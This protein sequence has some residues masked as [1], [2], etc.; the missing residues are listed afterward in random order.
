MERQF[1]TMEIW[2]KSEKGNRWFFV[3]WG[4]PCDAIIKENAK[5]IFTADG[6]RFRK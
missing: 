1:E 3:G 4:T 2:A 6:Y 5:Y